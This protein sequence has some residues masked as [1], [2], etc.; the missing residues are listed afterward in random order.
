MRTQTFTVT[1]KTEDEGD[2]A[3]RAWTASALKASLM[4]CSHN[5][6]AVTE[7]ATEPSMTDHNGNRITKG[8]IVRVDRIDPGR[9][10]IHDLVQMDAV[11]V[12]IGHNRLALEVSGRVG[13]DFVG[14]ECVKLVREA[15]R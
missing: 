8:A 3:E 4:A 10:A 5:V 6:E 2:F 13:R 9:G 12:G 1:L 14:P 15:I 7:I 11:V